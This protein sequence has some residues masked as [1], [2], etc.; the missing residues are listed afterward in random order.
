MRDLI[1]SIHQ[2]CEPDV[3]K[4]RRGLAK[5]LMISRTYAQA[6]SASASIASHRQNRSISISLA[7][8]VRMGVFL[9]IGND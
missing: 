6:R 9:W 7:R 3:T 8:S 2:R 5:S 4:I 1:T